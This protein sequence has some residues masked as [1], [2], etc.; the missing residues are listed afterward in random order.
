MTTP[1]DTTTDV[2]V[3]TTPS[4][5]NMPGAKQDS[6]PPAVTDTPKA[7]PKPEPKSDKAE[8]PTD[9][10]LTAD[11]RAELDR[12]RA[13]HKDEKKWE[14][15]AKGNVEDARRWN[16]LKGIIG[17]DGETGEPADP[18]QEVQKLRDDLESERTERIRE[19]VS[20]K[21]GVPASQII[22]KTE[23]EM[24]ASAEQALEWAKE[25]MRKAGVPVTAPASTVTSDGTLGAKTGQI[26]SREQ[27]RN[28][29]PGEIT[30]AY[31]EGRLDSM[32]GKG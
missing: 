26:T 30:A 22:G 31:R 21:S 7:D 5:A 11:E 32:M 4:P 3:T 27:L 8:T 6:V 19:K 29:S 25:F 9:T 24:T 1:A 28:M 18:L 16:A 12:L 23:D 14:T 15:R 2:P 10:T 20:N 13:I 17:G